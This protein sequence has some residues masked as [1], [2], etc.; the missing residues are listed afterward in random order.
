MDSDLTTST[1]PPQRSPELAA[2]AGGT[3]GDPHTVL[4]PHLHDGVVVVRVVRPMADRVTIV[5]PDLSADAVHVQDG[6]WE[7]TLDVTEVPDYRV[8]VTY[9]EHT[10]VVDDPYRF[11]P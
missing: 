3:H 2:I 5:T 4:G 6:I 9:G 8:Q 11:L 1:E 10:Q 7:A